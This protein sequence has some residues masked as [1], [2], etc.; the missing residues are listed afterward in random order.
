MIVT[1]G[2][3]NCFYESGDFANDA[4]KKRKKGGRAITTTLSLMENRIDENC[5]EGTASTESAATESTSPQPAATQAA[6]AGTTVS[7]GDVEGIN[8]R[9]V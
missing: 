2:F 7:R 5:L 1:R 6:G 3:R 9:D 8:P 4:L